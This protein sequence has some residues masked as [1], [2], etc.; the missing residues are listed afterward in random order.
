MVDFV[1]VGHDSSRATVV[2]VESESQLVNPSVG[3]VGNKFPPLLAGGCFLGLVKFEF[4]KF[5]LC[6]KLRVVV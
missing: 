4:E 1:L 3:N 2:V 6:L 5:K